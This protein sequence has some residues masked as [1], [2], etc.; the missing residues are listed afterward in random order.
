MSQQATHPQRA[1]AGYLGGARGKADQPRLLEAL[2]QSP[3][4]VMQVR[5]M[6]I[7]IA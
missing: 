7:C 4:G 3:R 2:S 1:A 6:G 5:P